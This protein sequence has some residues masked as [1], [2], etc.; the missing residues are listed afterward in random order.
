MQQQT[1]F[2]ILKFTFHTTFQTERH[3][4][5]NRGRAAVTVTRYSRMF[6]VNFTDILGDEKLTV[7]AN[8]YN[9]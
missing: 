5:K 6:A 8:F 2:H 7:T 9:M 3:N 4:T 1:R